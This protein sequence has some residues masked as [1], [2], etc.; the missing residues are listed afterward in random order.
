MSERAESAKRRVSALTGGLIGLGVI[1]IGVI[2]VI[3]HT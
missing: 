3:M 2:A 1:V